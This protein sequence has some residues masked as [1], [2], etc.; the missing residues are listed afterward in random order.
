MQ[1]IALSKF[2]FLENLTHIIF[3]SKNE[4]PYLTSPPFI[5]DL[6]ENT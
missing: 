3:A 1:S 2:M 5:L 6:Q 4:G